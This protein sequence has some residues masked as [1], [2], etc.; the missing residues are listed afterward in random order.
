MCRCGF[1]ADMADVHDVVAIWELHVCISAD[2]GAGE[3]RRE[4]IPASSQFPVHGL[5]HVG[6]PGQRLLEAIARHEE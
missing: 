2:P 3:H 1:V 6:H 4:S 5:D